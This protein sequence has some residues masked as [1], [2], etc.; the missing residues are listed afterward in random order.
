MQR[1]P[2]LLGNG[3]AEHVQDLVAVIAQIEQPCRR[4]PCLWRVVVPQLRGDDL[5]HRKMQAG[6]D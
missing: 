6:I 1:A 4:F 5:V 2:D 3:R